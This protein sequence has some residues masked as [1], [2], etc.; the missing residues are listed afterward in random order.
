MTKK[1]LFALPLLLN[2][3]NTIYGWADSV[4]SHMPVIGEPCNHWQCVTNSG[5]EKSDD[6]KQAEEKASKKTSTTAPA[7]AQPTPQVTK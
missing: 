7:A 3:C 5:Q 1:L 4:G 2:G 6:M